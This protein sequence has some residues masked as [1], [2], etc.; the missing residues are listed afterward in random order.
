MHQVLPL[1]DLSGSYL[2]SRPE[3]TLSGATITSREGASARVEAQTP[4]HWTE[5]AWQTEVSIRLDAALDAAA[6]IATAIVRVTPD[7]LRRWKQVSID[8]VIEACAQLQ[9]HW[10]S[11]RGGDTGT[12]TLL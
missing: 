8:P 7:T 3:W 5:L 4:F 2:T 12:L 1:A 10:R 9:D 6:T 11:A